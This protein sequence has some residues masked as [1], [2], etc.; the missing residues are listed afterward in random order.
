MNSRRRE[1]WDIVLRPYFHLKTLIKILT[2]NLC[3]FLHDVFIP[4]ISANGQKKSSTFSMTSSVLG[5]A[6]SKMDS[7]NKIRGEGDLT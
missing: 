3:A 6:H 5:A 1:K 2:Y 4:Q 7:Y